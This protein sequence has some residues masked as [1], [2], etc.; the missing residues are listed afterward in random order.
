MSSPYKEGSGKNIW[1]LRALGP[2][3]PCAP[4]LSGQGDSWSWEWGKGQ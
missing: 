3:W 1:T 2:N 4:S